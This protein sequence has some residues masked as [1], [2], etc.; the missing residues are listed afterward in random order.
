[1]SCEAHWISSLNHHWVC[2]KR[3]ERERNAFPVV[4][5]WK[6]PHCINLTHFS[7]SNNYIPFYLVFYSV[8]EG[9]HG[10]NS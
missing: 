10:I 5:A 9:N 4:G 2:L 3:E 1:M 8:H 6:D 7:P